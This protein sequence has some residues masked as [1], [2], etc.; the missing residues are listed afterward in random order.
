MRTC[1]RSRR[2]SKR[3]AASTGLAPGR[4]RRLRTRARRGRRATGRDRRDR[5]PRQ[6]RRG[7]ARRPR[8][9]AVQ[10]RRAPCDGV[11]ARDRSRHAT[12]EW[13]ATQPLRRTE[14]RLTPGPR[15]PAR[16]DLGVHHV[17]AG[18]ARQPRPCSRRRQGSS[19][20]PT[21]RS[22]TATTTGR[23]RRRPRGRIDRASRRPADAAQPG[24]RG[25]A[26]RR[27]PALVVPGDRHGAGRGSLEPRRLSTSPRRRRRCAPGGF[28]TAWWNAST[29][30]CKVATPR[31]GGSLRSD[32]A[33]RSP[34]P[35]RR[36]S[37]A[38]GRR[39]TPSTRLGGA[40][41]GDADAAST[42]AALKGRKL[43]DRR[44]RVERPHSPYF[45]YTRA[46]PR[47]AR[48]GER[49]Q[50]TGGPSLREGP[51]GPR[52]PAA[53]LGRGDRRAALEE[54][55]PRDLLVGRDLVLGLRDRRD[56]PG[57]GPR[58]R[59]RARVLGRGQHRDRGAPRGR[60][61]QLPPGLSGLS[62][63][64]RVVLRLPGQLRPLRLADRCLGPAH[65]LRD[66]RRRIDVL[67]RRADRFG[68]PGPRGRTGA[69]R[70]RRDRAHHARQP[71][72][73]ARV[74][75]HLRPPHVPLHR[76]GPADDRDRRVSGSSFS[77][78]ARAT[79]RSPRTRATRSKPWVSC[80]S[81]GPSRPAPWR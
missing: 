42:H 61:D 3:R 21:S 47:G 77:A 15:Q 14:G 81:C 6:P 18:R 26:S 38:R 11:D 2:S 45:R 8:D 13:L 35:A 39:L 31:G 68:D 46:G 19:V 10:R 66:D 16:S 73:P 1:A 43:G 78:R 70:R 50:L 20:T 59:R 57:P 62:V 52:R 44:V 29:T 32:V 5:G 4:R 55:G 22:C 54:E 58:R 17:D 48:G 65:R 25:P 12:R 9:R 71:A 7:R 74:G 76:V 72:R 33:G 49:P 69:D 30:A 63:G 53:C 40:P 75:Q 28:P 56:P 23:S 41:N 51:A 27:Q 34:P 60:R 24:Q 37:P 36:A 64:R 79:P 80:S 67:G